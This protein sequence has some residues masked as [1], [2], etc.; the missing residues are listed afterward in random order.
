MAAGVE[1]YEHLGEVPTQ[2]L[3]L[4]DRYRAFSEARRVFLSAEEADV[5]FTCDL[6]APPPLVWEWLNDP[7]KRRT[8][9]PRS[10]WGEKERPGGRTGPGATNHCSSTDFIEY[11]LDWR[12]FSYFTVERRRGPVS[13]TVTTVLTP[14]EE[15]TR[16]HW[17]LRLNGSLPR[18]ILRAICRTFIARAM[19]LT[20]CAER[21]QAC[22]A[23]TM[24]QRN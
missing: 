22:L 23:R 14:L 5:A 10:G 6:A 3:N 7:Q 15:G 2:S 1:A 13:I 17:N 24:A 8:W 11:I 9:W 20:P 19:E 18:P 4:D 12:P 16:L 21:L